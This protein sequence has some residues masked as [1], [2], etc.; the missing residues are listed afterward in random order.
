VINGFYVIQNDRVLAGT[1]TAGVYEIKSNALVKPFQQF[2]HATYNDITN[3]NDSLLIGG[4][5]GSLL[6]MN[7]QLKSIA[8]IKAPATFL[9]NKIYKDS[10]NKVWVGTS[11]GLMIVENR[12]ANDHQFNFVLSAAPFN[13]PALKN[14]VVN[15]ILEDSKGN[16]WIATSGALVKIQPNNSWQLLSEQN[17]LP[18]HEIYCLYQDSEK[19]IWIGTSL[20][21]VK[22]VTRNDIRNYS[23]EKGSFSNSVNYLLRIKQDQFLLGTQQGPSIYDVANNQFI[24]VSKKRD[25]FYT[26]FVKNSKPLLFFTN[27]N[28]FGKYDSINRRI[29]NFTLPALPKSEVYCSV[30]DTSGIIFN[31]TQNGLLIHISPTSY[32]YK[33]MP[34]RITDMLIDHQ[35]Y[36]WIATWD[37][38]LYRVK[39]NRNPNTAAGTPV[40]LTV[41]NLSS[42][43][44]DKNVRCLYDDGNGKVCVGTRYGGI[45]ILNYKSQHQYSP[46]YVNIKNGLMSNWARTIAG[47]ANSCIW[48][49]SDLGI[50]KLIPGDTCYRVFNFSR[51]NNYFT[52]INTILSENNHSLWLS[53]S[54][55]ITNIIDGL[56]EEMPPAPVFINAVGLA[57]T[58]FY[59]YTPGG[60]KPI[61]LR[62][63]Q[64]QANF[65]FSA[66][67]F[68]NEKQILYS[69]RL[70]GSADTMWSQPANLH[71]VYYA[72]L[73]AGN[74]RFEVR[75]V[76]WNGKSGVPARF[77]FIIALPFWQTWWFYSMIGLLIILLFYYFYRYRIKQLLHLQ[78]VRNRIAS[79]LHDDI[80]ATLTNINLLSEISRKNLQHPA[81]AEK[82][83]QRIS[84]E[85]TSSSQ[86]LNDIIWNVNSRNDSMQEVMLRMRRYAAE[87]FDNSSTLCHLSMDDSIGEKKMNMEQRRDV[88]LIYKE[89]MNNISK[90]A[91]AA[92]VWVSMQGH[93]GKIYLKIKDDGKGFEPTA[94]SN[95]NGLKNIRSRTEKWKGQITI[96]TSPGKGTLIEMILPFPE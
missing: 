78:N 39:Y 38:G 35:G 33:Q 22:L 56:S 51:I 59:N 81:E 94:N 30:M 74:Y 83:L 37:N 25:L 10:K 96:E 63:N 6:V 86:S 4:S 53:S 19:N 47:G 71:A 91:M 93:R 23:I 42:L 28:I 70:S 32:Y 49:G 48:V 80:G 45:A 41:E 60:N 76:G 15:D 31:G 18:S 24:P 73:K 89:A 67:A 61:E 69:Y 54:I 20:G 65:E 29:A 77:E 26:G 8:T 57:D 75:T 9:T 16:L 36:L 64:N 92:N 72:S 85:V 62:Y 7:M 87:L 14:D 44:P 17:G 43:L 58:T 1:D 52:K 95:R 88:Y 46:Q 12:P 34:Y 21:L 50:D 84:E 27:N 66:P 68:I 55:G 3:L 5:E 90:H 13:I 79:D 2:S 40:S 82:F 11:H